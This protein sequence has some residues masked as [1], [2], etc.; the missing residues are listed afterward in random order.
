MSTTPAPA[1]S[2]GPEQITVVSHS[3]LFYWWPVWF[4][5]FLLGILTLFEP[6]RLAVLPEGSDPYRSAKGELLLPNGDKKAVDE[7]DV[8]LVPKGKHLVGTDIHN[9][10]A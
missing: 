3:N 6:Y 9:P 7:M 8:V 2:Q 10:A 5:G 4:V 1:P